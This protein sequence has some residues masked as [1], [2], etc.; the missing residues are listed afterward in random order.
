MIYKL[1]TVLLQVDEKRIRQEN[2]NLIIEIGNVGK[3]TKEV[4]FYKKDCMK[5]F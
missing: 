5:F 2:E 1:K 4:V 3:S